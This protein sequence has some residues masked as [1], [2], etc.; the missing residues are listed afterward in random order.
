[1]PPADR[2]AFA[3]R[4]APWGPKFKISGTIRSQQLNISLRG[5]IEWDEKAQ[6][7]TTAEESDLKLG[8]RPLLG[9][10]IRGILA[11]SHVLAEPN[12]AL[13]GQFSFAGKMLFNFEAHGFQV[14]ARSEENWPLHL[15]EHGGIHEG[16]PAPFEVRLIAANGHESRGF[17]ALHV[18]DLC[19]RLAEYSHERPANVENPERDVPLYLKSQWYQQELGWSENTEHDK[20][21]SIKR[22]SSEG[23]TPLVSDEGEID[24]NQ[25]RLR[26]REVR[27]G[28]LHAA[29]KAAHALVQDADKAGRLMQRTNA[30]RL[31]SEAS[32]LLWPFHSRI[33]AAMLLVTVLAQRSR[34]CVEQDNFVEAIEY[35]DDA[36]QLIAQHRQDSST[37][38]QF[39]N[40][41]VKA[42]LQ[43]LMK[44]SRAKLEESRT[45]SAGDPAPSAGF[46]MEATKIAAVAFESER[47]AFAEERADAQRRLER[48]ALDQKAAELAAEQA[49]AELRA[50]KAQM[51]HQVEA[52]R[53]QVEAARDIVAARARATA[54]EEARQIADQQFAEEIAA[55][56]RLSTGR[57]AAE[58]EAA[59]ARQEREHVLAMRR[60]RREHRV[61]SSQR[62]QEEAED[63]RVIEAAEILSRAEWAERENAERARR[64]EHEVHEVDEL[65]LVLTHSQREAQTEARQRRERLALEDD[66]KLTAA[67]AASL[68]AAP[69]APNGLLHEQ[70]EHD[71]GDEDADGIRE[72]AICLE[73]NG[74]DLIRPCKQC[75]AFMHTSCA[76]DWKS[77]CRK[78][79]RNGQ[80]RE[81][82]CPCCNFTPF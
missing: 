77:E 3:C 6:T 45:R 49:A 12:V 15:R 57:T 54:D 71:R 10:K 18:D 72:C 66:M 36:L 47:A 1:M 70:T 20:S 50:E 33:D 53:R 43:K 11:V 58:Q 42:E 35:G 37:Q 76:A 68:P 30:Q 80:P 56:E 17:L 8:R 16:R 31:Y 51:Q 63:S 7:S 48:V 38:Q 24:L 65:A 2:R 75:N 4:T 28:G 82:R 19:T 73:E 9:G 62:R 69:E 13:E 41:Q 27:N 67:I 39:R 14:R 22:Q 25:F 5:F 44:S 46:D 61:E 60:S 78:A 64:R 29:L 21:Y 79:T 32:S 34:I 59:Q 52:R 74:D 40:A 81:P 55:V 26:I 23:D